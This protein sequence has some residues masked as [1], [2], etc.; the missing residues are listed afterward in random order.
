MAHNTITATPERLRQAILAAGISP[1]ERNLLLDR[2]GFNASG[3]PMTLQAA[4][5]L[6]GYPA[7]DLR[8]IE[9]RAMAKVR[10]VLNRP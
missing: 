10:E 4:A 6:R 8:G 2:F 1:G 7:A 9:I 3:Q 5:R